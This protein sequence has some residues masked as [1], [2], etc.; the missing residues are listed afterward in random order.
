MATDVLWRVKNGA[1]VDNITQL[2]EL[3]ISLLSAVALFFYN[4][5]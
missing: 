5:N 1:E 3:F 4:V 2:L